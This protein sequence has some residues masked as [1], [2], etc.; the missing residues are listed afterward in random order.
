[1]MIDLNNGPV[2]VKLLTAGSNWLKVGSMVGLGLTGYFSALPKGSTVSIH[3]MH[4]GEACLIGPGLI[5]K[6]TYHMGITTPPWLA[7]TA[8][9]GK[10]KGF[11][12]RPLKLR[13]MCVFPHFDHLALAV[14]KDLGITSIRQI[15]E[16]KVPLRISTAPTHLAHPV[17]WVLD[18][19]L[20]EYGMTIDDFE[21]WGGSVTYGDRQ[22]NLLEKVPEGRLD[23]VTAMKTNALDAIFDEAL[24]TLPWKQV[25]DAVDLNFLPIDEDVLHA[26]EKKYGMRRGAIPKGSLRGV[27]KDVPAID[28]TGWILYCHQDLPDDLVYLAMQGLDQQRAQIESLFQPHQGLTGAIDLSK[29]HKGVELPLHPGAERYYK[30]KGYM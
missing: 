7:R 9:E 25:A 30:S 16:Q 19:L 1:M 5:D 14:Q 18:M 2:E 13:S 28:F 24:M 6:G 15:K 4:T 22:P 23:R 29:M 3:T 10:G 26:L 8:A 17:G 11:S 12:E 20:A 21:K 27:T